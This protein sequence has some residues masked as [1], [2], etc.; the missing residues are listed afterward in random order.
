MHANA[1]VVKVDV[2]FSDAERQCLRRPRAPSK[3]NP[4]S[5]QQR[6]GAERFH[7]VVVSPCIERCDLRSPV[8]VAGH[9]DDGDVRG[10]PNAP[11]QLNASDRCQRE[12]HRSVRGRKKGIRVDASYLSIVP[13]ILNV[14]EAGGVDWAASIDTVPSTRPVPGGAWANAPTPETTAAENSRTE[15]RFL[16]TGLATAQVDCGVSTLTALGS[17]DAEAGSV[18]ATHAA[19]LSKIAHS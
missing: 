12:L 13:R 19:R 8:A 7:D 14:V 6:I 18:V 17:K 9:H 15:S 5:G 2:K 3:R 10:L 4:H 1:T 16:M 11:A